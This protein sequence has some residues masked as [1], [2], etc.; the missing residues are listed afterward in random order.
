MQYS[1]LRLPGCITGGRYFI[2]TCHLRGFRG[3]PVVKLPSNA[4]GEG[5][6]PGQGGETP[7]VSWLKN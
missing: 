7:H 4:R 5:S 3:S 6:I 1:R 2:K